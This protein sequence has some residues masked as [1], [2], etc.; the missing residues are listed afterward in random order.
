MLSIQYVYERVFLFFSLSIPNL[1]GCPGKRLQKYNFF[2]I[3][4]AFLKKITF[5]FLV[6]FV[7]SQSLVRVI[8]V[9]Q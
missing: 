5:F 8:P 1:S 3:S 4:Q 9:L 2:L 6:T 7:S